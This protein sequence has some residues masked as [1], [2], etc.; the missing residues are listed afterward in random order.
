M[1]QFRLN[2]RL[3]FIYGLKKDIWKQIKNFDPLKYRQIS[4]KKIFS[5]IYLFVESYMYGCTPFYF[6]LLFTPAFLPFAFLP[7]AFLPSAFR[8]HVNPKRNAVLSVNPRC[9]PILYT[10]HVCTCARPSNWNYSSCLQDDRGNR[11][12]AK[13]VSSYVPCQKS[14]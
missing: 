6:P 3:I 12:Y 7:S 13:G 10:A 9:N 1:Q 4:S 2:C 11:E 14:Q 5:I 8:I